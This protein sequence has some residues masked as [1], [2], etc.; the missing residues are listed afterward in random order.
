MH[1]GSPYRLILLEFILKL[2]S[3]CYYLLHYALGGRER[4]REQ[5]LNS[6][7]NTHRIGDSSSSTQRQTPVMSNTREH[8]NNADGLQHTTSSKGFQIRRRRFNDFWLNS[9]FLIRLPD[10]LSLKSELRDITRHSPT[11]VGSFPEKIVIWRAF[12]NNQTSRSRKKENRISLFS[13]K[14]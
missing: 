2:I 4:L 10:A 7:T 3:E 14:S 11:A 9:S 8:N 5:T 12:Q 1:A 6:V 13:N